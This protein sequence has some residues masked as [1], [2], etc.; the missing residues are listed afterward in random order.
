MDI[1]DVLHSSP[2]IAAVKDPKGLQLALRSDVSVIFLLFGTICD[3]GELVGAAKEAGKT[4][5]IHLDLVEGLSGRDIA[6]D[7]LHTK[8]AADGIISTK[9]GLLKHAR[10]L[11]LMTV[12]RFFLLDSIALTTTRTQLDVVK[13]DLVEV[14]PGLLFDAIRE[15]ADEH[16]ETPIIAGGLVKTKSD[17]FKALEAGAAAVSTSCT[18]VWAM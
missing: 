9:A 7:Y 14:L 11:G 4:V 15:L 13:P 17:V 18:D 10:S 3:I 2:V 6:V 8:T 5:F 1:R 12:Q 16:P